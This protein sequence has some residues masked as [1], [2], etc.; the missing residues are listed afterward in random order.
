M[1]YSRVHRLL[2]ILTLIQS[3]RGWNARRL[4]EACETTVRTIYRDLSMLEGAG[5]P[6]Y[7]DS[8]AGGYRVRA[9]FFMPPVELTLE[10]ALSVVCL[11]GCVG[12]DGQIPLLQPAARAVNKIRSQLPAAIRDAL[13]EI[14]PHVDI[15]LA[16]TAPA[17]GLGDVYE[18][19]R[20]AI[21]TR[22]ALWC[23]YASARRHASAPGREWRTAGAASG[24]GAAEEGGN[25]QR[26]AAAAGD[27]FLFRPYCLFFNQRAWYVIGHHSGRG[28]LRCLKLNRFTHIESA[29][30]PYAI[31]DDFSLRAYLGKAWRM[32]PGKRVWRVELL[33]DPAFAETVADTRWHETQQEQWLDDGSVILRFEVAGLDEIVWW[34]LSMGPHCLV[35]RPR[36]LAERVRR[37][38]RDTAKR[39]AKVFRAPRA[40]S[41]VRDRHLM[42]QP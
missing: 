17:D 39:Y 23:R 40:V 33:F 19:I 30:R 14:E 16:A 13:D 1:R 36:V 10:E 3:G 24:R 34:V 41:L 28:G 26:P 32:I 38:A 8:E 4:A 31:P 21:V 11:A 42:P 35:R 15:R 6:Y 27:R 9:D 2:R 7:Y 20:R 5:I 37:L 25:G 12:R 22:R 29:D 18:R